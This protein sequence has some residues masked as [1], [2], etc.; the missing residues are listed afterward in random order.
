LRNRNITDEEI[1]EQLGLAP[2]IAVNHVLTLAN[3]PYRVTAPEE[4]YVNMRYE[5][6]LEDAQEVRVKPS[7]LSSGERTILGM[8]LLLYNKEERNIHPKL[9]LLDEPDAYLHPAMVQE[10][11]RVMQ[12]GFV[13]ELGCRVIT[14]TH[15]PD[16]ITL[17][18]EG[19]L[20]ELSVQN[21]KRVLSAKSRTAA[22]ASISANLIAVLPNTRCVL[23]ED[24]NDAEFYQTALSILISE[25]HQEYQP[26]PVFHP[27]STNKTSGGK[28]VVESWVT[29]LSN[30]GLQPLVQGLI[31]GDAGNAPS[32][33]IHVLSRYSIENFLLDPIVVFAS[34]LDNFP[35]DAAQISGTTLGAGDEWKLRQESSE[36]LQS[37]ADKILAPVETILPNPGTARIPVQFMSSQTLQYPEWLL[38]SRGHDLQGK[39]NEAYGASRDICS[40]RSLKHAFE[41]LR[42][43]PLELHDIFTSISQ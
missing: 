2:W 29:R 1:E 18:P 40:K 35:Q 19:S 23:V 22:I 20:F 10:F 11:Y 25:Y 32:S 13:G 17:V 24:Q 5:L 42:M 37:I 3:F 9:F 31:D 6:M 36:A 34:L 14:T 41:R 39:F 16:T 27:A 12:E 26:A 30:S 43:V 28:T 38:H 8:A 15:R 4:F 33:G 7:G 21:G